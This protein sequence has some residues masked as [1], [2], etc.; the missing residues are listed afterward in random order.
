M[1]IGKE[2]LKMILFGLHMNFRG[3][4]SMTLYM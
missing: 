2:V 1:Q 4:Q 3:H